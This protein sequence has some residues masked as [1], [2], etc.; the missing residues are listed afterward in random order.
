MDDAGWT[1]I[2]KDAGSVIEAGQ[3]RHDWWLRDNVST[4]ELSSGSGLV[5]GYSC[6]DAVDMAVNHAT[7]VGESDQLLGGSITL[8]LLFL[9]FRLLV[10]V[11]FL[12]VFILVVCI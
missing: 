10:V 8:N 7:K 6:M 1:L 11:V 12:F 2:G 3:K 4:G 9:L 5:A